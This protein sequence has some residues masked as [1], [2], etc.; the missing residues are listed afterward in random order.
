MTALTNLPTGGSTNV[1]VNG[2]PVTVTGRHISLSYSGLGLYANP[3]WNGEEGDGSGTTVAFLPTGETTALLIVTHR[4]D[5]FFASAALANREDFFGFSDG[6][7]GVAE[8][9]LSAGHD[10]LFVTLSEQHS[11]GGDLISSARGRSL[12]LTAQKRLSLTE[13]TSLTVSAGADRFLGGK[14]T[15]PVGSIELSGG[16]WNQR[17]S[18]ASETQLGRNATISASA[19]LHSPESGEDAYDVNARLSW[20]F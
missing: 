4:E 11:G 10:N 16:G 9:N 1:S 12:T 5:E 2:Q 18:V 8:L 3:L 14:A 15:I 19:S 6:H 20:R 17:L 13:S 7:E